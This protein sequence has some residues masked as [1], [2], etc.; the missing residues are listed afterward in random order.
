MELLKNRTENIVLFCN[1]VNYKLKRKTCCHV[2]THVSQTVGQSRAIN[3]TIYRIELQDSTYFILGSS[4]KLQ[5][6]YMPQPCK[7][8]VY[9]QDEFRKRFFE[10]CICFALDGIF[11]RTSIKLSCPRKEV[12]SVGS[13]NKTQTSTSPPGL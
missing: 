7:L 6:R 5:Y 12:V 4:N 2:T 13:L 8:V 11:M 9:L 1:H 3:L 10:T